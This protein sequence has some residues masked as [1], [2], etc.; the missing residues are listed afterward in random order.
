[1]DA[2]HAAVH[3]AGREA[4][5]ALRNCDMAAGVE[6][7]GRMEEASFAVVDALERIAAAGEMDPALLR[8]PG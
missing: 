2:P 8:K 7:V 1:M 3:K 6:A 5:E 4:L